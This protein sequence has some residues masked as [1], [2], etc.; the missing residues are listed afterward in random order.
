MKKVFW[1]MVLVL[2]L[3]SPVLADQRIFIPYAVSDNTWWS[4]LCV[5]NPSSKHRHFMC[6]AYSEK[7]VR[8]YGY[9]FML[10][11]HGMKADLLENFFSGGTLHD[12]RVSIEIEPMDGD[13]SRHEV[14][15]ATLYVGTEEGFGFESYTSIPD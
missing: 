11:P 8:R 3:A 12:T 9:T 13:A 7:G 4:G 1:S 6:T 5:H 10:G 2:L 14:F 15:R